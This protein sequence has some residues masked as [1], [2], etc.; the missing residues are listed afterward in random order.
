MQTHPTPRASSTIIA[1]MTAKADS[2]YTMYAAIDGQEH[3]FT[4]HYTTEWVNLGG[5][6]FNR[7][8]VPQCT[9]IGAWAE[10]ED[11]DVVFAGDR[12]E[13]EALIG[14]KLVGEWEYDLAESAMERGSW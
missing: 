7:D 12:R 10:D 5:H 1:Q 8:E 6:Y 3:E 11:S 9:I 13:L 4:V 14:D 2:E